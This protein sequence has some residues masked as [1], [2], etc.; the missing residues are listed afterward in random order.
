MPESAVTSRN[1]RASAAALGWVAL[2]V[3]GPR[4]E[5]LTAATTAATRMTTAAAC[6]GRIPVRMGTYLRN[7]QVCG[8]GTVGGHF[9]NQ[10]RAGLRKR[11]VR[12]RP[13]RASHGALT[14]PRPPSEMATGHGQFDRSAA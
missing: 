11:P 2:G 13:E 7:V 12:L 5:R 3:A 6:H 4:P 9:S 14:Q 8:A 10:R 1:Q